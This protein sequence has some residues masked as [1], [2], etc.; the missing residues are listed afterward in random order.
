MNSPD[1]SL[2]DLERAYQEHKEQLRAL[3]SGFV[4]RDL[5]DDLVQDVWLELKLRP[6]RE[7]LRDPRLYLYK[8]AWNVLRKT[9]RLR[10][11][12]PVAH[13]PEDLERLNALSS[14]DAGA[15]LTAEQYLEHLLGQLPPMYAAV[16]VLCRRD[17]LSYAEVG[18]R[19]GI[20][21]RSVERHMERVL[22]HLRN[23]QW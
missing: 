4:A 15:E 1:P 22:A 5:A 2:N 16:L 19:L 20:S 17:G 3:F 8:V 7:R 18:E 9:H 14:P 11:R 6:P 23:A 13:G 10:R 21:T 12:Q